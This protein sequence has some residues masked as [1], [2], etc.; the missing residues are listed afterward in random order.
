MRDQPERYEIMRDV[1]HLAEL[2]FPHLDPSFES[3]HVGL[4]ELPEIF[5]AV[6]I[7]EH[8]VELQ[9]G[10][11]LFL[12][13]HQLLEQYFPHSRSELGDVAFPPVDSESGWE[14][15][16]HTFLGMIEI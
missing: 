15:F 12:V 3:G 14:S 9:V 6:C 2:H 7:R 16:V 13:V 8:A 4:A 5:Y 10:V 1:Y 11:T